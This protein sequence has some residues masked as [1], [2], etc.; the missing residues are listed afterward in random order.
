MEQ[1]NKF[2]KIMAIRTTQQLQQLFQKSKEQKEKQALEL[3]ELK[4]LKKKESAKKYRETH[5]EQIRLGQAIYRAKNKEKLNAYQAEY[6]QKEENRLKNIQYQEQYRKKQKDLLKPTDEEVVVVQP[7]VKTKKQVKEIY[8]T[9]LDN[10]KTKEPYLEGYKL[11]L[12]QLMQTSI[13]KQMGRKKLTIEQIINKYQTMVDNFNEL[14]E[15]LKK[16]PNNEEL[17][18]QF[19]KIK[20]LT[21]NF[22][23]QHQIEL[24]NEKTPAELIKTNQINGDKINECQQLKLH[25]SNNC[26][27]LQLIEEK[28]KQMIASTT[29]PKEIKS[30]EERLYYAKLRA[31][32]SY[33]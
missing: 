3:Q 14:K 22:K 27:K 30:I 24:K 2:Q 15:K 31:K 23:S 6:R 8:Q 10:L 32:Y 1:H 33:I 25:L 17:K 9:W 7:P 28:A 20:N 16:D 29:D 12:N 18:T 11:Y 19:S 13:E 26:H 21:Y 5:R 4:K